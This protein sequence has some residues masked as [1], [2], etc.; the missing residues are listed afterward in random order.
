[1]STIPVFP[2][3][4]AFYVVKESLP[5]GRTAMSVTATDKDT[6]S[7]ITYSLV[8]EWFDVVT[9]NNVGNIQIKKLLDYES[10]PNHMHTFTLIAVD[11]GGVQ[12]LKRTS[13]VSVI[14]EIE[15][16]NTWPPEFVDSSISMK[17][18]DDADAPDSTVDRKLVLD[19]TAY[20][21]DGD[22]ITYQF[23]GGNHN[24]FDINSHTGIIRLKTAADIIPDNVNEYNF[25]VLAVDDNGCCNE[26][27]VPLH[28]STASVTVYIVDAVNRKP[29]F[30]CNYKPQLKEQEPVGTHVVT[31]IANDTSRGDKSE[32]VYSLRPDRNFNSSKYFT[33]DKKT[34][35]ITT[36]RV[37]D[38]EEFNEP[39]SI[40]VMATDRGDPPLSDLCTFVV[41]LID[42]ND[43]EPRFTSSS[44]SQTLYTGSAVGTPG[45]VVLA[46]DADTGVN[47]DVTYQLT[48][49]PDGYF[50]IDDNT[51]GIISIAQSLTTATSPIELVVIARDGGTTQKSSSVTIT[52]TLQSDYPPPSTTQSQYA[53]SMSEVDDIGTVVGQITVTSNVDQPAVSLQIVNNIDTLIAIRE[54]DPNTNNG[55]FDLVV[56]RER[57]KYEIYPM[58]QL[59]LRAS[60][61]QQEPQNTYIWVD[62]QNQDANM[63]IPLYLGEPYV[64]ADNY[65]IKLDVLEGL[66]FP[67]LV[68]SVV[69]IDED[70]TP[71]FRNV[72]YY[73]QSSTSSQF[74]SINSVTGEI[75]T[76]QVFDAEQEQIYY[77]SIIAK[78]GAPSARPNHQPEGT[79]NSATATVQI[80][81]SDANDNAPTFDLQQYA[82]SIP[83]D[84][85]ILTS[86]LDLHASDPDSGHVFRFTM[87]CNIATG[88][89][90][91]FAVNWTSGVIYVSGNLDY[92]TKNRYNC[93]A[94]VFDGKFTAQTNVN[95]TVLDVNDNP[96]TFSQ[97]TYNFNDVNEGDY[98]N[99]PF[100]IGQVSATDGDTGRVS[101]TNIMYSILTE[102]GDTSISSIFELGATS[103]NLTVK[104][105][106]DRD[107]Q[108]VIKFIV[109]AIDEP[110]SSL[111][112]TS[113]ATVEIRPRDMND[114]SPIFDNSTLEG[115]VKEELAVGTS[116]MTVHADDI[117]QGPNGE[118]S[119]SLVPTINPDFRILNSNS[120][121]IQTNTVIDREKNDHFTVVLTAQD[122]A[123]GATAKTTT[124][125]ATIYV[126][127]INDNNPHCND[128]LLSVSIPET[129]GGAIIAVHAYDPDFSDVLSYSVS[130]TDFVHFATEQ[131]DSIAY[132]RVHNKP[133]YDVG[134]TFFN[135]SVTVTDGV[136]S[137]VCYVQV[138]V[139]DVNDNAPVFSDINVLQGGNFSEDTAVNT[140]VANFTASDIDSGDNKIFE[141]FI[142]LDSDPNKYFKIE[143]TAQDQ[144]QIKIQKELDRETVPQFNLT[145]LAIDSGSPPQTGSTTISIV[146]G[147]VN[148]NGPRLLV[149]QVSIKEN[150]PPQANFV[151]LY[152]FD[153]D[154]PENG[155]PFS[156]NNVVC[157]SNFPTVCGKFDFGIRSVDSTLG[158]QALSVSSTKSLD[159][160]E[161]S[162][163]L[164]D[165]VIKDKASVSATSTLTILI[166]G[167]NDNINTDADQSLFAYDYN[168]ILENVVIG[169]V[170]FNDLDG[171]EDRATKTFEKISDYTD[172]YVNVKTNGSIEILRNVP[173]GSFD[174]KVKVVDSAVKIGG[175]IRSVTSTTTVTVTLEELDEEAPYKAGSVRIS[176][177]TAAE[178]IKTSSNGKSHYDNL[179]EKMADKLGKPVDYV[180]IVTVLDKG[181]DKNKLLEVRF[182][183]HGSP[184]YTSA[185]LNGIVTGNKNEFQTALG[186]KIET[187]GVSECLKESCEGGCWDKLVVEN[188]PN[189]VNAGTDTKVGVVSGVVAQCGCRVPV[190]QRE[191]TPDYCFNDGQCVKDDYGLL[192]CLC[193]AA[194]DGPRCQN[195]KKGF[196][197]TGYAL[198]KPLEQCL[199]W[200]TSIEFITVSENGL[201]FY[202]G[203]LNFTNPSTYTDPT[204]YLVLQLRNGYPELSVDLGTGALTLYLTTN[205]LS[206]GKWHHIN[207]IKNGKMITLTVD[208]CRTASGTNRSNCEVSG[209]TKST[210][211]YLNINTPLQMGGLSPSTLK[212][213][214]GVTDARFAGCM[215]NLRHKGELYDLH[216]GD[217]Y[218]GVKDSCSEEDQACQNKCGDH[219][220]CRVTDIA[221]TQ[222]T[223]ECI[224]DAGY[225]GSNCDT[226][227]TTV[228][229]GVNSFMEWSLVNSFANQ[230]TVK[231]TEL[232]LM[233]RSRDQQG[234]LF[235]LSSPDA[236]KFMRLEIMDNVLM[237]LYNLG[238]D[239]GLLA[240]PGVAASDGQWHTVNIKRVSKTIIM[241]MD[242]G[243]GPFYVTTHGPANGQ[244]EITLLPQQI[245]AGAELR[246][247]D[248][249]DTTGTFEGKDFN[250]SCYNDIR[251]ETAW[252]PMTTQESG[253]NQNINLLKRTSI[254]NNCVRNDCV[255]ITCPS[256][257]V[258]K[259]LWEAY[260]CVCPSGKVEVDNTCVDI[261]YCLDSPCMGSATCS[262]GN[263]TFIC[264]C[265]QGWK[266]KRCNQ[267]AIV[268]VVPEAGVNVG[269]IVGIIVAVVLVLIIAF[270]V[271]LLYRRCA[272]NDDMANLVE[273]EKED[274]DIRENIVAYDEEGAGE[275]DH[276]GYDLNRLRKPMDMTRVDKPLMNM[277]NERPVKSG[278]PQGP[279]IGE[280]IGDRLGDADEDPV[281]PPYDTLMELNY[282]G[283]GSS[284]GSL[285]SLNTSSSGGDQDYDYLN[286]WGPKFA[287]LADMYNQYEDSD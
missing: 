44:Y 251:L 261:N 101:Q 152:A 40:T 65:N 183:A 23:G 164:V 69:A 168:G 281:A 77:F 119:Y 52:M 71:A 153:P 235:H 76:K 127:D 231:E 190:S 174:F 74:F 204:D 232:Q 94:K 3:S 193:T 208:Y 36:T 60:N 243:E 135:V 107:S 141:F 148:D 45:I 88:A 200:E 47:A 170:G 104:G 32:I 212:T 122:G 224:C 266:G 249:S 138:T 9:V 14:V 128:S 63:Q 285:S 87:D 147:D 265:P 236:D 156:F 246:Y 274:Y 85:L 195:T 194:F 130:T 161:V 284:A 233:Y 99:N 214:T 202:N 239:E 257:F 108:P 275:E 29:R 258:C 86:V 216:T 28:T 262:N 205:K 109:R 89:V 287:K 255:G 105:L 75:T 283:G 21:P 114:N 173:Y 93:I 12:N 38:R 222:K 192:S 176:G 157:D 268:E 70:F 1:M 58:L 4:P 206:D 238:G 61:E 82:A 237:L 22:G 115:S 175:S 144:G 167:E 131:E 37:L 118:V 219:G 34:G 10:T 35:N 234:V 124:A 143:N 182:A 162:Q 66:P 145:L 188:A 269:L 39:I 20:D 250:S 277:E 16:V 248:N 43:H 121:Q 171:D 259:G 97:S 282:E 247:A 15:N 98:L 133:D 253:N 111:Q 64:S 154:S 96:P 256:T 276:E 11:D 53:F 136:N 68:G 13:S 92:E 102:P 267:L 62:L 241:S 146:L 100:W 245:Y 112:Q 196:T 31:T 56:G 158:G 95:I 229:F 54:S 42:I 26:K 120:G 5:V 116:V 215:R 240:M 123:T 198:F 155:P 132:L 18:L 172:S 150:L 191:C 217:V 48:Q 185:R 211:M 149:T 260:S 199:K 73:E 139:E 177:I 184:Y 228:D 207:I 134:E 103:G 126:I 78:D 80:Q 55:I 163:Y 169:R 81:I 117:D 41:D 272:G 49:N 129:K 286:N 91:P 57:I 271:V 254:Q 270:L 106:L 159:R 210:H 59:V 160:E 227:T 280:F 84:A 203:P 230:L 51:K 8:D 263:G 17:V 27:S 46:T 165:V 226:V 24:I 209:Y 201:I 2:V 19:M 83:E 213:P 79:P 67:E 110:S 33:I 273:D 223:T 25:E 90:I 252:F 151:S 72:T 142:L 264:E 187:I 6:S 30:N 221:V 7:T 180:Q 225:R 179:R 181:D 137:D 166:E 186:G 279:G 197:G 113:Y 278:P 140:V 218:D 125:T 189:V 178:F 220:E 244:G 242:G 50:S